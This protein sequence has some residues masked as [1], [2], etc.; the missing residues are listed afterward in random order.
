MLFKICRFVARL[1][2]VVVTGRYTEMVNMSVKDVHGVMEMAE[3]GKVNSLV[4]QAILLSA[5]V[6]K[7]TIFKRFSLEFHQSV[8]QF[9]SR[10]SRTFCQS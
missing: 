2:E 6:F 1:V 5:N 9:G 8:Y 4:L 10:S 7:S 3:E